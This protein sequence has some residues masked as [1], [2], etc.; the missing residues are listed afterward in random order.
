MGEATDTRPFLL[1]PPISLE[2]IKSLDSS[3]GLP[4]S[5]CLCQ[6]P[7]PTPASHP[8]S[9]FELGA[10]THWEGPIWVNLI[11]VQSGLTARTSSQEEHGRGRDGDPEA[12]GQCIRMDSGK[13]GPARG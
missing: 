6:A 13:A 12:H 4:H 2:T 8:K 5:C 3:P 1:C 9:G 11:A 7:T 10:R